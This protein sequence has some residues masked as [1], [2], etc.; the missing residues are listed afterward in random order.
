MVPEKE[1]IVMTKKDRSGVINPTAT[2][3][4]K[5][6]LRQREGRKGYVYQ[7]QEAVFSKESEESREGCDGQ[8]L[9]PQD[10]QIP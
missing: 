5:A 2:R 10:L 7:E 4:T 1:R 9:P 8:V 6:A 3:Q